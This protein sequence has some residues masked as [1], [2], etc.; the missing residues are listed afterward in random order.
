[1]VLVGTCWIDI[2]QCLDNCISCIHQPQKELSLTYLGR[3]E[4][5]LYLYLRVDPVP[6]FY[7]YLGNSIQLPKAKA[8][9]QRKGPKG[10]TPTAT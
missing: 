7:T 8:G 3:G 4:M 6:I 5:I 2:C 1:M 9:V 10:E